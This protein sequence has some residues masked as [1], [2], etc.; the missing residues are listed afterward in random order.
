M[1]DDSLNWAPVGFLSLI[2]ALTGFI[3]Y[4]VETSTSRLCHFTSIVSALIPAVNQFLADTIRN[5]ARTHKKT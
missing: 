1:D 4:P 5:D 2:V 3:H